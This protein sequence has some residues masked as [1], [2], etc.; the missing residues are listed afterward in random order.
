MELAGEVPRWIL[1]FASL[2]QEF[3]IAGLRF[4]VRLLQSLY[5]N[6]SP[7]PIG[8]VVTNEPNESDLDATSYNLPHG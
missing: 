6:R 7:N 4:K 2:V 1:K 8:V 3:R 5:A